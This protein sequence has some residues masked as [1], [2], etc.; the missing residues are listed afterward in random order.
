[1]I[2]KSFIKLLEVRKLPDI[3]TGEGDENASSSGLKARELYMLFL[4]DCAIIN[5]K[6]VSQRYKD[7]IG[8]YSS[9]HI[10]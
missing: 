5:Q 10:L 6:N 1:M 3:D 8:T 4:T 9:I 7:L 2:T